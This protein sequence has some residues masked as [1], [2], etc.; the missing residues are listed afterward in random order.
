MEVAT[1]LHKFDVSLKWDYE[2]DNGLVRAGNRM[3]VLVG[4]PPEF[5]GTDMVWSPEHLL[6]T[7]VASCY[8]TTFLSFAK[9]MR[10]TVT[11]F[12]IS[13]KVE[14][15]KREV[16]FEAARYYLR[17][18]IELHHN[19]GQHILDNLLEKA[20]KYCFISNSVK[21][22]VIVDPSILSC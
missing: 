11:G 12:R 3:P 9:R 4:S 10:V 14:F 15:E 20:K 17:P 18:V 6:A 13:C 5:G 16:G 2:T 19:P 21:G 1:Q 8:V 22:E 7:A